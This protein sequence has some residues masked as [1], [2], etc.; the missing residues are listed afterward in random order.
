MDGNV[1]N[2]IFYSDEAHFTL[3]GYVKKQNCLIWVLGIWSSSSNWR[4]AITYRKSHCLVRSLIRRCDWTLLLSKRRWNDYHHQFGSLLPYDNRLLIAYFWRIQLGEYVVLTRRCHM[5][6]NSS[7]YGFIARDIS[8]KRKFSSWRYRLATIMWFHIIR[9]FFVE[10]CE[11][12][13]LCR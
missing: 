8:W 4:E 11:R 9:L 10:L 12:T 3:G 2:K 7:K 6:H 13:C 5:L 1:S